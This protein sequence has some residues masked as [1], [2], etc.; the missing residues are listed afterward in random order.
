MFKVLYVVFWGQM[1]SV[2][3]HLVLI[4]KAFTNK[5]SETNKETT[6]TTKESTETNKEST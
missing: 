6:E 5:Y 3:K 1:E 4:H 2:I